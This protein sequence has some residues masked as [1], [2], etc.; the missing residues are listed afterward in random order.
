[1]FVSATSAAFLTWSGVVSM[2]FFDSASPRQ[3]TK[4]N[5]VKATAT[6]S[7]YRKP[8]SFSFSTVG[9]AME[10]SPIYAFGSGTRG[11]K[12][13]ASAPSHV[14]SR[15]ASV[16]YGDVLPLG[17]GGLGLLRRF[18]GRRGLG[19]LRL[20]RSALRGPSLRRFG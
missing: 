16:R 19:S 5:E 7:P 14:D 11:C 2:D 8:A 4:S 9:L 18:S 15:T 10:S 12:S 6:L 3:T 20:R 1:M 17:F 13:A